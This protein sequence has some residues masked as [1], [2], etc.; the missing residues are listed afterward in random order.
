MTSR[1]YK[2]LFN[3]YINNSG[4]LLIHILKKLYTILIRSFIFKF[5][6]DNLF[7]IF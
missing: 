3:V 6:R 4:K 5:E 7:L 2:N 1:L